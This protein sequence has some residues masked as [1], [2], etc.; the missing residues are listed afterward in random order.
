MPP[1][2]VRK[3]NLRWQETGSGLAAAGAGLTAEPEASAAVSAGHPLRRLRDERGISQRE[4]AVALG[5]TRSHIQRMEEKKCESFSLSEMVGIA[6]AFSLRLEDLLFHFD[7]RPAFHLNR[8]R[9][10][11][12]YRKL[13]F[14]EGAVLALLT[15]SEFPFSTGLLTLKP[16][17]VLDRKHAPRSDFIWGLVLQ[18]EVLMTLGCK[19]AFFRT[20]EFFKITRHAFY[21]MYNPHSIKDALLLMMAFPG[22]G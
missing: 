10:D 12:P 19:E 18:G 4:L 14:Q 22:L 8:G 16:K 21:E 5:L 2:T 20:D 11:K 6:E 9:T 7:P 15:R 13:E 3:K 17:T 1:D